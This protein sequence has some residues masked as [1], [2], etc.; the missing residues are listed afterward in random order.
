MHVSTLVAALR[1]IDIYTHIHTHTHFLAGT[2]LQ[3]DVRTFHLIT[4]RVDQYPAVGR[5]DQYPGRVELWGREPLA[6]PAHQNIRPHTVIP[7]KHT[8]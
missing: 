4:G 7:Y 5:V 8:G 2:I 6:R 3:L 1:V